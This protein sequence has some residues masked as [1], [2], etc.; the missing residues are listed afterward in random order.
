MASAATSALAAGWY[1]SSSCAHVLFHVHHAR[2]HWTVRKP[3]GFAARAGR[4]ARGP[5][6]GC[7]IYVGGSTTHDAIVMV[8]VS[9]EGES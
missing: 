3:P 6:P 8:A 5:D 4:D 7:L 1:R 9:G 2:M